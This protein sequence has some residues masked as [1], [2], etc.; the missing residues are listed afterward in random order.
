VALAL[1]GRLTAL[2]QLQLQALW[3]LLAA[4]ALKLLEF[5]TPD[6]TSAWPLALLLPAQ[7]LAVALFALV[8]ART[9]GLALVAAGAALNLAVVIANG[10][11]MPVQAAGLEGRTHDGVYVLLDASTRLPALAD[12]I[13]TPPPVRRLLSPG[14]LVMTTGVCIAIVAAVHTPPPRPLVIAVASFTK[15][16]RFLT[17]FERDRD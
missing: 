15:L 11:F 16:R 17:G 8:N 13:L 1:G 3:L 4:V 12:I 14:D 9:P 7:L 2:A 6:T 5:L 10:G